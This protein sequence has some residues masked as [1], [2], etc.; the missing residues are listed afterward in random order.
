[1]LRHIQAALMTSLT[2]RQVSLHTRVRA[3][4]S[5]SRRRRKRRP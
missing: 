1:M 4:S 5:R 2:A 3:I